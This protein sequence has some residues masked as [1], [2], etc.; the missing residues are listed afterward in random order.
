MT[1][2]HLNESVISRSVD[3]VDAALKLDV[4]NKLEISCWNIIAVGLQ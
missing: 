4:Q 3:D 1:V 2:F